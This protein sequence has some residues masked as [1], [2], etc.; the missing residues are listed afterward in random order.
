M[1]EHD[2]SLLNEGQEIELGGSVLIRFSKKNVIASKALFEK[3]KE[4]YHSAEFRRNVKEAIEKSGGKI[5]FSGLVVIND[6]VYGYSAVKQAPLGVP[7]STFEVYLWLK[8]RVLILNFSKPYKGNDD[9]VP[10]IQSARDYSENLLSLN[11]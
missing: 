1:T 2:L 3:I 7:V 10:L 5:E 8:G 9:F 6:N 4:S 11:Q